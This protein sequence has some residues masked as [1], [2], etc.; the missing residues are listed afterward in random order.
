MLE[1]GVEEEEAPETNVWATQ[2]QTKRMGF[3]GCGGCGVSE[4]TKKD[5]RGGVHMLTAEVTAQPGPA[6]WWGQVG[7]GR[8]SSR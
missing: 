3:S 1:E 2:S 7:H 6:Y 5:V 8:P 4:L